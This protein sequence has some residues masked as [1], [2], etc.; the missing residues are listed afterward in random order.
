MASL[1][2]ELIKLSSLSLNTEADNRL[3]L[4]LLSGNRALMTAKRVRGSKRQSV[5][6]LEAK[7]P[8]GTVVSPKIIASPHSIAAWH[9]S[10]N[11]I[12]NEYMKDEYNV[13]ISVLIVP[14]MA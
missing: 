4:V 10:N 5:Q 7:G 6:K 8:K 14:L 3:V 13:T 1:F 12:L 2:T 9:M 11:M